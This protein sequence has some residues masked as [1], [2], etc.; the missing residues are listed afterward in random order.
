M[1][2]EEGFQQPQLVLAH[3]LFLLRHGDVQDIEK[4]RL[5][6]EVFAFVKENGNSA[7]RISFKSSLF[8]T[9]LTEVL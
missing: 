4:V 5:K 9:C 6:D 3:K 8:F 7:T 1:E 2:G